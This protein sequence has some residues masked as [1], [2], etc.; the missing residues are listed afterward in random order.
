MKLPP[1]FA[2]VAI[3][4]Q[5]G[6]VRLW[7]PLFILWV[8]LFLL[9]IPF[10][11]LAALALLVVPRRYR[12]GPLARGAYFTLCETRGTVVEVRAPRSHPRARDL[13]ISLH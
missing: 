7:F 3:H 12:F 1:M 11:L 5:T 10:L 9:L 8:L 6:V 4:R 2:K 13:T